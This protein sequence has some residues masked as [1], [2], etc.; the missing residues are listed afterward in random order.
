MCVSLLLNSSGFSI[1]GVSATCNSCLKILHY[2]YCCY[3]VS[4]L[5]LISGDFF[6]MPSS[7]VTIRFS[8]QQFNLD[9][10]RFR[11]FS[12]SAHLC[13]PSSICVWSHGKGSAAVLATHE[14]IPHTAAIV[15][16]LNRE[17]VEW[18]KYRS[19]GV[20]LWHGAEATKVDSATA[21]TN[22]IHCLMF[23]LAPC[24]WCPLSDVRTS[25]TLV[26]R[27]IL[28]ACVPIILGDVDNRCT[29]PPYGV[30]H[31][32]GSGEIGSW[33]RGCYWSTLH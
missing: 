3:G 11:F 33:P 30:T 21:H 25:P 23:S 26:N 15:V 17:D 16:G 24:G 4:I 19:N 27:P 14:A 2:Y 7:D 13:W 6:D 8:D 1:H 22:S 9:L 28:H 32:K 20:A 12:R 29:R 18:A 5:R 31:R 10:I